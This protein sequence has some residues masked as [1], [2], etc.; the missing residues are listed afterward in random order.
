MSGNRLTNILCYQWL[1]PFYE[2]TQRVLAEVL[3]CLLSG[4]YIALFKSRKSHCYINGLPWLILILIHFSLSKPHIQ[5]HHVLLSTRTTVAMS[6]QASS[7]KSM[8]T[9]SSFSALANLALFP[10]VG[11]DWSCSSLS[12]LT[13]NFTS[14]ESLSDRIDDQ[15]FE[16][17]VE[18]W[19]SWNF[20]NLWKF[21]NIENNCAW[22]GGCIAGSVT[23]V[24]ISISLDVVVWSSKGEGAVAERMTCNLHK[25]SVFN[26]K[27]C[28]SKQLLT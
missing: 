10:A 17:T 11:A 4:K 19:L 16:V 26:Q 7:V 18:V 22:S 23:D 3:L 20:W 15:G 12:R 24:R 1:V 28:A 2:A 5:P 14:F 6:N 13:G 27:S 9:L 21:W 25:V 8:T